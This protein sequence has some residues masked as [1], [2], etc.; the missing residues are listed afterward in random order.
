VISSIRLADAPRALL[1]AREEDA[2]EAAVGDGAARRRGQP[3]R[4]GPRVEP[5]VV[6]QDETRAEVAEVGRRIGAG[7]QLDDR[8]QECPVER[9]VGL[10]A[11]HGGEPL[12][13]VEARVARSGRGGH[14]L[15]GQ[16]VQRRPR[17][18]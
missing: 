11:S 17:D 14:R 9:V 2:E 15:L 12:V 6:A 18:A 5:V 3:E 7:Q 16:H 8:V 10:G 13:D 1:I 4:A